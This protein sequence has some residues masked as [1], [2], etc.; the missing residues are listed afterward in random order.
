MPHHQDSS[1]HWLCKTTHSVNEFILDSV[2]F[3][4]IGSKMMK[5]DRSHFF[6]YDAGGVHADVRRVLD[7]WIEAGRVTLDDIREQEM[8]DGYYHNQF[9]VVNDC[10]HR[11]RQL[12]RWLFFFDVDEYMWIPPT[13]MPLSSILEGYENQTQIIIWQKPMSRNLC[14]GQGN[15][16]NDTNLARFVMFAS[17]LPH[18]SSVMQNISI[19]RYCQ[20]DTYGNYSKKRRK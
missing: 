18:S 9:M 4:T 6:M 16:A 7:P 12:S 5:F 3:Y 1:S 14:A 2:I 15:V 8:F 11:A 20:C 17:F 10:F 19:S 13:G